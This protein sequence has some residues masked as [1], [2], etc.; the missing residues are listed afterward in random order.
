LDPG[1]KVS[2]PR[3]WLRR[4]VRR[5]KGPPDLFQFPSHPIFRITPRNAKSESC[6]NEDSRREF[7]CR[8][9]RLLKVMWDPR[10]LYLYLLIVRKI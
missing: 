6:E 8:N 10:F 5:E 2:S 9:F 1:S 3:K 4:S 7:E